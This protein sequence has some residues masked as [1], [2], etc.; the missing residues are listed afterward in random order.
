MV[1]A[2]GGSGR[3]VNCSRAVERVSALEEEQSEGGPTSGGRNVCGL[4]K[5]SGVERRCV[6]M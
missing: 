4:N 6:P 3:E 5:I 1:E 2:E